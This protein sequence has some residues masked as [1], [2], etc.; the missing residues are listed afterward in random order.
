MGAQY[1]IS[2]KKT[3]GHTLITPTLNN[4]KIGLARPSDPVFNLLKNFT[5]YGF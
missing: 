4:Y 1:A 2:E 3:L 5:E